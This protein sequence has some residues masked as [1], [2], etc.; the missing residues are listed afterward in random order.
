MKKL[1]I[2]ALVLLSGCGSKE[3]KKET[4]KKEEPIVTAP[5]EVS[6]VDVNSKSRN[7]AV[8]I[9]N[10]PDAL[11]AQTG[12]NDAYMIYEMLVEGGITRELAIFKDKY[13]TKVGTVRSSRPY[14]LDYV[15]ENDA[16]YVHFGYSEEAR[17]DIDKLGI[18]NVN[19]L[20]DAGFFRDNPFGIAYEH[21]A[22]TNLMDI[23]NIASGKGYRM[24][25]ESKPL[26][27]YTA[28]LNNLT[29]VSANN[30]R[31]KYSDSHITGYVYNTNTGL[32]EKNVNGNVQKD[33]VTGETFIAKNLIILKIVYS[34]SYYQYLS[35]AGE[36]TGYY[37]SNGFA[38]EI[39]WKKADRASKTIYYDKN[40]N[41]L[42]VNDGNTYIGLMPSYNEIVME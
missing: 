35:N 39:T 11:Q 30:V 8:M 36:G 9:N 32:Y 13:P 15:M 18:N 41:V 40:G 10:F 27:T 42:E 2:F 6:V 23:L 21:T 29:G 1:L 34:G 7:I 4:P 16:I 37:I 12:L 28:E 24:E 19:G 25:T 26:L 20:A 33:S 5:A 22:F 38:N 3:V 14:F 31:I 17:M